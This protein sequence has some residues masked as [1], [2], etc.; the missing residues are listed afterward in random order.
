LANFPAIMTFSMSAV[1]AYITTAC[2]AS[3]PGSA[4]KMFMPR[5]SIIS[6]SACLPGASEPMRRSS[7]SAFAPP[8]VA[9]SSA[10]RV[11]VACGP[12]EGHLPASRRLRLSIARCSWKACRV[13][14]SIELLK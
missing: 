6:R 12:G 14:Q 10:S 7:P 3:P 13:T 2:A 8:S 4:G 1:S 5:A 9:H 11:R